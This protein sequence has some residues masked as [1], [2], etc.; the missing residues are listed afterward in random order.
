MGSLP[1]L[2]TQPRLCGL[3]TSCPWGLPGF[4]LLKWSTYHSLG[5]ISLLLLWWPSKSLSLS[6]LSLNTHTHTHTHTYT[7]S[8]FLSEPQTCNL[9]NEFRLL[10]NMRV[11]WSEATSIF[12]S[13]KDS[14]ARNDEGRT[15]GNRTAW[16]GLLETAALGSYLAISSNAEDAHCLGQP[17]VVLVEHNGAHSL[18]CCVV[19]GCIHATEAELSGHDRDRLAGKAENIYCLVCWPLHWMSNSTSGHIHLA[20]TDVSQRT[21]SDSTVCNSKNLETTQMPINKEMDKYT[22]GYSSSGILQR[23]KIG[24]TRAECVNMST[25]PQNRMLRENGKIYVHYDIFIYIS[26]K[27]KSLTHI[28]IHRCIYI[29]M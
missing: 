24:W 10:K 22:M 26:I 6:P 5:R 11:C 3:A 20:L 25:H 18:L 8:S 1:R 2:V 12:H 29:Y 7:H 19:H 14:K 9:F 23:Q 27:S 15:C 17:L 21:R 13:A 4:P 16:E 28:V